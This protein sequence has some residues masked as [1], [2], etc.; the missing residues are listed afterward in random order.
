ML[1]WHFPSPGGL[2]A[3]SFTSGSL[4]S[5]RTGLRPLL[6]T[7]SG[8]EG[9]ALRVCLLP[10]QNSCI[11]ALVYSSALGT[12]SDPTEGFWGTAFPHEPGALAGTGRAEG[13][14]E[15]PASEG[16][17][18]YVFAVVG[19]PAQPSADLLSAEALFR[20]WRSRTPL[21]RAH[22]LSPTRHFPAAVL[23]HPRCQDL[24]HLLGTGAVPR[25]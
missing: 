12:C 4:H 21:K 8:E 23:L 13:G 2:G 25:S 22:G 7:S 3:R 24:S 1:S 16:L 14:S 9:A 15:K 19:Q 11:P 20:A 18:N 10:V 6:C 17:Q 5:W